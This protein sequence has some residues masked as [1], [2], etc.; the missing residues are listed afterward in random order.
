MLRRLACSD[1]VSIAYRESGHGTQTV[2]L[3]H[4]WMVSG[5]VWD[6]ILPKLAGFR[7]IVPDLRG[8]G[9]SGEANAGI[10]LERL[11]RDLQELMQASCDQRVHLVGHSMGGLIAM[12]AAARFPDCICSLALLSPVPPDGISLPG[13]VAETFRSAGGNREALEGILRRACR[14]LSEEACEN[15]LQQAV[16]ISPACITAG[17]EA[18][19]QAQL[20]D[21]VRTI[22]HPTWVLASD[23]P[24][25]PPA[26]LEQ[27]VVGRISAA[28]LT[29][30]PGAGH[31]PQVEMPGETAEGLRAFWNSTLCVNTTHANA[32]RSTTCSGTCA[33]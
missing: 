7:V 18:W 28:R 19:S 9:R 31:Y 32:S 27:K 5:N 33:A 6:A 4:G 15:L 30:L 11:A 24:F 25:L 8:T 23:D 3:V 16:Q 13:E 22:P 10:E 2:V 14:K 20:A 12:L 29:Y 17:F 26:L 21:Q 1:G